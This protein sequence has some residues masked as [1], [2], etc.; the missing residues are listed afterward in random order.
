MT[1][2]DA[3][4]S[5]IKSN[6]IKLIYIAEQLGLSAY[7]LQLKIDN[8]T[9]FKAGEIAKLCEILGITSLREKEQIFFAKKVDS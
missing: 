3:L 2:T 7:G 6:G 9:E 5:L 4:R 8:K 1:D